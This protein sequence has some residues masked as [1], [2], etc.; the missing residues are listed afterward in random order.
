MAMLLNSRT[1]AG[2][3]LVEEKVVKS[4]IIW[5]R[6][7]LQGRFWTYGN[8][9]VGLHTD[10]TLIS[11]KKQF[12]KIKLMICADEDLPPLAPLKSALKRWCL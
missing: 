11:L 3:G 5:Y 10:V 2:E 7:V 8:V 4:E 9:F 1:Q 12:S 6:D